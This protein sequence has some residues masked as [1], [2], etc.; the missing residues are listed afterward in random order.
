MLMFYRICSKFLQP[1]T[2]QDDM[3]EDVIGPGLSN[4]DQFCDINALVQ[5]LFHTLPLRLLVVDWSNGQP[6]MTKLSAVI[7]VM[8]QGKM[9]SAVSME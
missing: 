6:T 3:I 7:V 1:I 8:A 5:T 9:T 4:P 2:S